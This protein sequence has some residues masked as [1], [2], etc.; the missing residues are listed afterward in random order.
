MLIDNTFFINKILIPNLGTG[1]GKVNIKPLI[2][3]KCYSFLRSLLGDKLYIELE[4]HFDDELNLKADAPLKWKNLLYGTTY[5]DK[6]WNGLIEAGKH[7][8]YSI[9]AN[10]VYLCYIKDTVSL[11]T[12]NGQVSLETKN[13]TNVSSSTKEV[14]V[15]NDIVDK[16]QESTYYNRPYYSRINGNVFI[17]WYGKNRVS[18]VTLIEY[19]RDNSVDFPNPKL[20]TPEGYQITYKNQLGL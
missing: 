8:K 18:T 11:T 7:Y 1:I 10:Y 9:L 3:E 15:W 14:E 20:V 17:D 4:A 13:A 5:D 19:L 12:N 2:E 6:I 16:V